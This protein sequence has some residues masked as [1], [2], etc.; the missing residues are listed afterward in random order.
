MSEYSSA[1]K[2]AKTQK[3]KDLSRLKKKCQWALDDY[4]RLTGDN[5]LRVQIIEKEEIEESQ[6]LGSLF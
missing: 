6:G 5:S 3:Q 4:K 1:R 2:M